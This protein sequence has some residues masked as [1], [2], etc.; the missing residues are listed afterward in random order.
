MILDLLNYE[1][2]KKWKGQKFIIGLRSW[3]LLQAIK[4]EGVYDRVK[5]SRFKLC[6]DE[7]IFDYR[8]KVSSKTSA[9][10]KFHETIQDIEQNIINIRGGEL[11]STIKENPEFYEELDLQVR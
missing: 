7:L 5:V 8:E 6:L 4:N 11:T 1:Q 10:D 2:K 9:I 3:V